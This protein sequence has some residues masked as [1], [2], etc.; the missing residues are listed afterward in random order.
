MEASE[1]AAKYII[2][3]HYVDALRALEAFK[4]IRNTTLQQDVAQL[5]SSWESLKRTADAQDRD[6]ILSKF[7]GQSIISKGLR[8][9]VSN[10]TT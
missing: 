7:D 2:P 3:F 10:A 4:L 8:E 6:E 5:K 9:R 1:E